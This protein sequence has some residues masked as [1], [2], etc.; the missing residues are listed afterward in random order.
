L[1]LELSDELR[2]AFERHHPDSVLGEVEGHPAG[3]GAQLEHRALRGPRQ[4]E[5]ERKV[6]VVGAE[7][8][9]LPDRLLAGIGGRT[10]GAARRDAHSRRRRR[11]R[12][13]P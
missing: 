2:L 13:R 7:L 4:L 10:A 1:P 6:R 8:D 11:G 12:A 9:L 5:P 3:T